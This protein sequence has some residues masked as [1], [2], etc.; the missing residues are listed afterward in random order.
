MNMFMDS[1]NKLSNLKKTQE[2]SQPKQIPK[3]DHFQDMKP[4]K[5]VQPKPKAKKEGSYYID[6]L[7]PT[8]NYGNYKNPFGF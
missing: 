1:Y 5:K 4:Q 8:V 3:K 6:F 2:Q 7:K